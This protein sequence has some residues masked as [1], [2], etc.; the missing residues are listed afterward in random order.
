MK[1]TRKVFTAL[2]IVLFLVLCGAYVYGSW[3]FDSHYLPNTMLNEFDIS[4]KTVN[5]VEELLNRK[6]QTYALAV[7]ERNGGREK[8][9]SNDV[10]MEYRPGR[11]LDD[12]LEAQNP[13][14]W[15][16]PSNHMEEVELDF[17]VDKEKL[18]NAVES[19]KCFSDMQA[20]VDARIVYDDG[21]RVV[22]EKMGTQL[23][24]EQVQTLIN[25]AI[26]YGKTSVDLTE[27]YFSPEVYQEDLK[28]KCEKLKKMQDIIITYDFGDDVEVVDVKNIQKWLTDY[29]L[30]K[31]KVFEFVQG[32]ADKYDTVGKKRKF[33]TYDDRQVVIE[34][35]DYGWK[36]DSEKETEDLIKLLESGETQI[37]TPVYTQ[38]GQKR[39]KNDIGYTYLELDVSKQHAVFYLKGDPIVQ[40]PMKCS[41]LISGCYRMDGTRFG[42]MELVAENM[43]ESLDESLNEILESPDNPDAVPEDGTVAIAKDQMDI[44]LKSCK[45]NTPVIVY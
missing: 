40:T 22:E 34:G 28:E 31:D 4:F 26:H 33:V 36:L 11:E 45:K 8:I 27:C 13:Y 6:V 12:L 16:I 1:A 7:D 30:D 39:E 9:T 25:S 43:E 24:K 32:L 44:I 17:N 15:I 20:P 10:G 38:K 23:D 14:L 5:E 41:G 35:G 42:E 21:F 18:K 3:F 19:L 29:E 2:L 37:H